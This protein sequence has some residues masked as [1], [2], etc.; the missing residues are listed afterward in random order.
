[1]IGSRLYSRDPALPGDGQYYNINA[2]QM[3]SAAPRRATPTRD[4]SPM[5]RA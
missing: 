4:F 1:M 2:D 3:A 5:F